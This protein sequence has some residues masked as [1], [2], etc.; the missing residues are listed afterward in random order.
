MLFKCHNEKE[1]QLLLLLCVKDPELNSPCLIQT[2]CEG[3][4]STEWQGLQNSF[5]FLLCLFYFIVKPPYS[6]HSFP[7]KKNTTCFQTIKWSNYYYNY[8]YL[9]WILESSNTNAQSNTTPFLESDFELVIIT[10][11]KLFTKKF[12]IQ[13]T[14]Q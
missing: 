6:K 5:I 4:H 2:I 3:R 1:V 10:A 9:I 13:R 8:Y 12:I 11:N 14:C 7:C